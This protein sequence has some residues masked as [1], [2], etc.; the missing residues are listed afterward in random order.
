M[1]FY[2]TGYEKDEEGICIFSKYPVPFPQLIECDIFGTEVYSEMN[3]SASDH[4][5]V[6]AVIEGE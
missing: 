6:Y 1:S 5:G 2:F 4:Y 3:L